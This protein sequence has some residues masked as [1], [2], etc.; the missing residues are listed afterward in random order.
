[1]EMFDKELETI[2]VLDE[3]AESICRWAAA[4]AGVIVIVPVIGSI[5]LMANEIYLLMRLAK[6]YDVKLSESAMF[7][8]VASIAGTVIGQTMATMIPF[9]P[10]QI[11]I[12]VS[13]TYAI[14][15]VGGM[16]IKDGMPK[17][18]SHYIQSFEDI[19]KLAKGKVGELLENPLKNTPL[20]D[21]SKKFDLW[22]K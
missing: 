14:G 6:L 3:E 4:R 18:M 1:M 20:G 5:S 15:K 17:D 9:P 21:E 12:A 10:L 19:K 8:F 7:S 13:V 2:A 16:W 11:P 22:K